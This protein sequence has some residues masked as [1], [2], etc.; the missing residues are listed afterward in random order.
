MNEFL[1]F[2]YLFIRLKSWRKFFTDL[3]KSP[4]ILLSIIQC[5]EIIT[6]DL[7]MDLYWIVGKRKKG[8]VNAFET[9]NDRIPNKSEESI[10]YCLS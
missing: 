5:L 3:D 10:S 8:R 6:M 9:L 7:F 2:S 1:P 4:V